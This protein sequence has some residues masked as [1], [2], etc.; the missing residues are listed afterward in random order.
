VNIR[1]KNRN[2]SGN[3]P[4]YG[5]VSSHALVIFIFFSF[6][7]GVSGIF[8]TDK[9][10]SISV[11][12][13]DAVSRAQPISAMSYE[14]EINAIGSG[15]GVLKYLLNPQP[16]FIARFREDS[17]EFMSFLTRYKILSQTQ[18]EKEYGKKVE[19]LFKAYVELGVQLI[20]NKN[21]E[22]AI[23]VDLTR[24]KERIEPFLKAAPTFNNDIFSAE[25]EAMWNNLRANLAHIIHN[26]R[27]I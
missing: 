8:L 10:K 19:G 18:Q 16:D 21:S 3:Y 15:T 12:L 20:D 26:Y 14:M 17:E 6:I 23:R 5:R 11:S 27:R 2:T 25:T 22:I 1:P 24:S 13:N 4:I 7:L 9:I